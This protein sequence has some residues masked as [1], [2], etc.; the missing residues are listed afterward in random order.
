MQFKNIIIIFCVLASAGCK[1]DKDP[2]LIRQLISTTFD[3]PGSKVQAHPIVVVNQYAI[4]DWTQDVK[5][6]RALLA[7]RDGKWTLLLCGGQAV[8]DTMILIQSG[9]PGITS[10]H[11]VNQLAAAESSLSTDQVQRFDGFGSVVHFY[12]TSSHH[13]HQ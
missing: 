4:V 13:T 10:V 1:E 5:A 11:L 6:G 12:G 8:K 2:A 3:R 9:V 7:L